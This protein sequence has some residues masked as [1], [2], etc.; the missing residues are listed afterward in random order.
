MD[1][2]PS[3][4]GTKRW[5][6]CVALLFGGDQ[7]ESE[8]IESGHPWRLP[9]ACELWTPARRSARHLEHPARRPLTPRPPHAYTLCRL[10]PNVYNSTRKGVS[11]RGL[12]EERRGEGG[13]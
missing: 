6:A 5:R 9:R 8:I 10:W 2:A 12:S 1:K 7:L 4:A 13:G 3:I 11:Q